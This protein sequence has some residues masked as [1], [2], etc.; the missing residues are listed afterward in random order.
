MPHTRYLMD[1]NT[2]FSGHEKD[3]FNYMQE[4][5]NELLKVSPETEEVLINGISNKVIIQNTTPNIIEEIDMRFMLSHI[6]CSQ[7]GFY[8]EYKNNT[9]LVMN[10]P[11]NNKMYEKS[12][13]LN[14]TTHLLS[15]TQI[16]WKFIHCLVHC[17][18]KL[19]YI[20]MEYIKTPILP[21][22][23]TKY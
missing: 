22:Q 5:F 10:V 6:G 13:L 18:I 17:K 3:E 2:Y 15:K 16:L 12:I 11:D 1:S 14:A 4:G 7:K 20:L 9:W 8:V 19:R 21:L 23:M